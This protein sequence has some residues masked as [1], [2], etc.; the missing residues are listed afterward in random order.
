MP[1]NAQGHKLPGYDIIPDHRQRGNLVTVGFPSAWTSSFEVLIL[2]NKVIS[3]SLEVREL[4]LAAV[5]ICSLSWRI[6]S[7]GPVRQA[8]SLQIS[9]GV[10][11]IR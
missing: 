2:F 5:R 3:Q 8:G 11:I 7:R 1:G 6:R 4:S 9:R 10:C